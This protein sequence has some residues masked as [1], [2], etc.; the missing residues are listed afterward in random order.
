MFFFSFLEANKQFKKQ[1]NQLSRVLNLEKRKEKNIHELKKSKMSKEKLITA[2][3]AFAGV[4][5]GVGGAQHVGWDVARR[6][7]GPGPGALSVRHRL[8]LEE[9]GQFTRK[10]PGGR[11]RQL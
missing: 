3:V 2:G 10:N 7:V 6:V 9:K 11:D 4:L 1:T 8:H 5:A